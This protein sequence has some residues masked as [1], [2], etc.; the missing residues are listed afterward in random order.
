VGTLVPRESPWGTVLR[1]WQKAVKEKT[2]GEVTI[3][4]Y[5]NATQGDEPTLISKVRTGQLDSAIVSAMGL[6]LIDPDINVLQV[7][8]LYA[9]WAQL[10][11]ARDALKPR[12]EASFKDKGFELVGWG[13]IGLMHLISKGYPI[14]LPADLKGKHPWVWREDPVL[15][16]LFQTLSVTAV[17][18][19]TT[20][21]LPLLVTGSIDAM[22]V[23]ALEAEQLQ[24]SSRLDH[25]NSMVVAPNVGGAVVSKARAEALPPEQ[26]AIIL[27]TIK[28]ATRALTERIR[29][30][31]QAS[32]DRLKKRM[33]VIDPTPDELAAWNKV[34]AEA[35]ARLGRGTLPTELLE[36]ARKLAQ[37]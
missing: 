24:W 18:A 9:G 3:E 6:G 16:S 27:D 25:I 36:Q 21:V 2:K 28:I 15:P 1:A 10:D 8:G 20:E 23:S 4:I 11:K 37:E 31:D 30:E 7:P 35:R 22:C 5:W 17:P 13:D 32:M 12:F 33:T 29:V 34:F 19:S 26:R 14:H